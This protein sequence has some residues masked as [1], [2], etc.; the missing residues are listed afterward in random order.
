MQRDKKA[1]MYDWIRDAPQ[2]EGTKGN[3]KKEQRKLE[4]LFDL[5]GKSQLGR[6]NNNY[7]A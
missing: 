7:S 1:Q 3:K 2:S 5:D 6:T 4:D